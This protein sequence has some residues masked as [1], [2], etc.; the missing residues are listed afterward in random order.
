[1][2]KKVGITGDTH[3][4]LYLSQIEEALKLNI[5]YLFITGDFG[6]VWNGSDFEEE[7]L[8][9]IS[10]LPITILFADGN[11]ENYNLLE[12][13]PIENW[14]GGKVQRIRKNILRLR[15]GEIYNFLDKDIFTFGGAKS[16]DRAFGRENVDWFREEVPTWDEMDYAVKNLEKHNNK[17]D[18]IISH[19]CAIDTLSKIVKYPEQDD[20]SNFLSYIKENITYDKW[21]F[22]HL[23]FPLNVNGKEFCLF[24]NI[25]ILDF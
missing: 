11:H 23:H 22:G 13:Y 16:V 1:M 18:Y 15:R 12:K 14:M 7:L 21:F 5:D 2:D 4:D 20:T 3:G 17:V 8:D 6:Y 25:K 10:I 19:T 24:K 9:D